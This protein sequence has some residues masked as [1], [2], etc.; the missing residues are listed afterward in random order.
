MHSGHTALLCCEITKVKMLSHQSHP[1]KLFLYKIKP[2]RLIQ[3]W[4]QL[5]ICTAILHLTTTKTSSANVW[6]HFHKLPGSLPAQPSW[7]M[8]RAAQPYRLQ[9]SERPGC[10]FQTESPWQPIEQNNT[11]NQEPSSIQ[12]LP[13][14]IDTATRGTWRSWN[15][16]FKTSLK[17]WLTEST[18]ILS[19][20]LLRSAIDSNNFTRWEKKKKYQKLKGKKK[21]NKQKVAVKPTAEDVLIFCKLKPSEKVKEKEKHRNYHDT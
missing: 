13:G 7:P 1:P 5:A 21:R 20:L 15:C 2:V 18:I 12:T 11:E 9:W 8:L 10:L 4:K 19:A 16:C 6:K 17:M 3:T 14:V